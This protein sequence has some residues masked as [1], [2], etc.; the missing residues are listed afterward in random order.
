V[1]RQLGFPSQRL[2]LVSKVLLR[3]F[4]D[5]GGHLITLN[6]QHPDHSSPPRTP[7]QVFYRMDLCPQNPDEFE[8]LWQRMEYA[9]PDALGAVD[10]RTI[11]ADD[12]QIEVLRDCLAVH[13]ARSNTIEHI[14]SVIL[15]RVLERLRTTLASGP[16]SSSAGLIPAGP[17]SREMIADWLTAEAAQSLFDPTSLVPERMMANYHEASRH[18]SQAG[19]QIVYLTEGELLIGDTPAHTQGEEG[20]DVVWD[21]ARFVWMPLGRFHAMCLGP[22]N[23]YRDGGAT[24]AEGFNRVQVNSA[25]RRVAWHPNADMTSFVQSVLAEGC[26]YSYWG[27]K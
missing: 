12:R 8:A 18:I 14:M 2:H 25:R 9:L 19:V 6:V 1:A 15:P 10:D 27:A 26:G 17:E 23:E 7:N 24:I 22:R 5:A 16:L 21:R 13:F 11:L 4:C 20:F 3:R